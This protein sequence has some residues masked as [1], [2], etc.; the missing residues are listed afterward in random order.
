MKDEVLAWLESGA[1]LQEGI[2][3]FAFYNPK[4]KS[5]LTL[6]QSNHDACY[7]ILLKQLSK[8][9]GIDF[10]NL[11]VNQGY[12]ENKDTAPPKPS[13]REAKRLGNLLAPPVIAS[14]E[15]QSK[16]I[17]KFRDQW[18]FLKESNCP[19][20][21]KILASNKITAYHEY[22]AAHGQLFDCTNIN[23]CFATVKNLVENYIENRAVIK[24]FLYYREHRST[25]GKHPIFKEFEQLKNLRKQTKIELYKRQEKLEH[26]I[27][28]IESEI[29]KNDKPHLLVDRTRRKQSKQNELSE[30][31]RLL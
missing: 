18:P 1:P 30:I 25:L 12:S 8:Q 27:W 11:N 29:A 7:P 5:F 13:L 26:N 28:R 22:T 14:E 4:N 9:A 17:P 6:I 19:P 23:E 20:E 15:K 21:L 31:M 16:P 24:E 2:R 10:N 3:L